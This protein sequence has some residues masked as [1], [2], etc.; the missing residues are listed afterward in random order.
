MK[1]TLVVPDVVLSDDDKRM[2]STTHDV[3]FKEKGNPQIY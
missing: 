1:R 2:F 3:F